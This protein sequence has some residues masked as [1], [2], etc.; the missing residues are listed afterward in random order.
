MSE[1]IDSLKWRYATKKFDSSKKLSDEQVSTLAESLQLS[2]SS[3]GL[4]P[5]KFIFVSD[6]DIKRELFE[7]S[8]K[9]NQVKDC[10]HHLVFC[11]KEDFTHQDVDHFL[12]SC[13]DQRSVELESLKSYGDVIK[14]FLAKRPKEQKQQWMK[15]QV[16]LALGGLLVTCAVLQIDAC[17][18]EGIVPKEYDRVL[19]LDQSG[20]MTTVACALGF[21]SSDDK[22][23]K[24]AKV[25][26]PLE[27]VVEFR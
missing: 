8:W 27:E 3:F 14:A 12:E 11:H 15:D 10:S 4:Q 20:W 16:Y 18:M 17:P 23:S 24:L 9:Q 7:H 25:R 1:L 2:A 13:V 19:G 22:Y 5:W 6:Q 21:R 26:Y